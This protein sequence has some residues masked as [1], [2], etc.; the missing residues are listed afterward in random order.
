MESKIKVFN[1]EGNESRITFL[2]KG[3]TGEK[4]AQNLASRLDGQLLTFI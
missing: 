4:R 1:G 2:V 3:F